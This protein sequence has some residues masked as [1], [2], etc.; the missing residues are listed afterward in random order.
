[1]LGA[2]A[3]GALEERTQDPAPS[4]TPRPAGELSLARRV[5]DSGSLDTRGWPEASSPGHKGA[6]VRPLPVPPSPGLG[7][8]AAAR[9]PTWGGGG[10]GVGGLVGREEHSCNRCRGTRTA[11]GST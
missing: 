10:Q 4:A 8:E 7:K 1:M 5:W 2:Q 9:C 6:A 11:A 3:G